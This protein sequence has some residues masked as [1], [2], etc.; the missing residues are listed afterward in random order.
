MSEPAPVRPLVPALRV[1]EPAPQPE[2]AN[3]LSPT[4][5]RTFL[6]CSAKWWFRYGLRFPNRRSLLC[7]RRNCAFWIPYE[8]EFGGQ[9]TP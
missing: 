3:V 5:V 1:L 4:Q 6:D 8:R 7:S 2:A 9:V